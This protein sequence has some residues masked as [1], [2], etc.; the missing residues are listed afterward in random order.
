M[1]TFRFSF[2]GFALILG[3]GLLLGACDARNEDNPLYCD[4]PPLPPVGLS[5][6]ALDNSVELRWIENQEEDFEY[7]NVFV[8]SDYNGR[9]TLLGTT[10]T[11]YYFDR[12]A[13]NG[14]KSYYAVSA[15]DFNGHESGLS[16]DFTYAIARPEGQGVNL[17]NRMVDP[18][19]AG[20]DFSDYR[21]VHYDTDRTDVY[22]EMTPAGVPYFVV[23]KDSEIQDMGYSRDLDEIRRAPENGWSP[24]KDAHIIVGH[25][26]VIRTFDNRYAKMRVVYASNTSVGF[27]WAYQTVPNELDL[28]HSLPQRIRK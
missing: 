23:W 25:T 24:T 14:V 12:G 18:D 3:M 1:K 13:R 28:R 27:D 4:L 19:R 20:Y 10:R 21:V 2:F 7:Y 22:V 11:A 9:Y 15:V 5:A 6:L 8:S 17:I 26:Y 16:K